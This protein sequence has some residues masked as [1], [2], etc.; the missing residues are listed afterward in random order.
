M[1]GTFMLLCEDRGFVRALI[2]SLLNRSRQ[3]R[4]EDS[5]GYKMAERSMS[6]SSLVFQFM[7]MEF[8][9]QT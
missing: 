5:R 4:V 7:E 2:S 9:K 8:T 3:A 1:W 6:V